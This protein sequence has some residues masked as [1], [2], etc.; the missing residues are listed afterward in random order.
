MGIY[1]FEAR[2]VPFIL[3]GTKTHTIRE[4]RAHPDKTGNILHLYS[5]LR[6]PGAKLLFRARC[7]GV[8]S[9][10]IR[11]DR[12]A[13]HGYA[14]A[15][16]GHLL[17]DDEMT[18]LVNRDGFKCFGDFIDYWKQRLPFEGQIIHW[19]QQKRG[20]GGSGLG[21]G[22]NPI[23][24][25]VRAYPEFLNPKR[26]LCGA[27]GHHW[28]GL[29]TATCVPC[30]RRALEAGLHLEGNFAYWTMSDRMKRFRAIGAIPFPEELKP[31]AKKQSG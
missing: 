20:A 30:V 8:Q 11:Q 3:A 13:K 25:I 19:A 17:S 7:T 28:G 31:H 16:D 24:H 29:M 4:L 5:G 26:A 10:T 23:C 9:I 1:N 21:T 18:D 6:H 22:E 14:I 12:W 2:F 27:I 15:I